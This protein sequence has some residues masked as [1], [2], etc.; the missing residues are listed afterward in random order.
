MPSSQGRRSQAERVRQS[1]D[2]LYEATIKLIAR[3]G[4]SRLTV[5]E[6]GKEA[7]LSPAQVT[8]RFGSKDQL[9]HATARKIME[10]LISELVHPDVKPGRELRTLETKGEIYLNEVVARTDLVLAQSRLIVES[11]SSYPELQ[12]IVRDLNRQA[13]E[14]TINVLAPLQKRGEIR[15]DFDLESFAVMYIGMMRGVASQYL[16]EHKDIDL[17]RVHALIKSTCRRV[18]LS[19]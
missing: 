18:L 14:L 4:P 11:Q 15:P 1:E 3:L 17:D 12:K 2:A 6:I 7:G 19:K 9:L 8:H 5:A 16:V 13:K 10:L